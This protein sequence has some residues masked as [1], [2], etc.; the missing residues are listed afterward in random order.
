MRLDTKTDLN[1]IDEKGLAKIR[2]VAEPEYITIAKTFAALV[3]EITAVL[4]AEVTAGILTRRG[5]RLCKAVG[6]Y[7]LRWVWLITFIYI[8]ICNRT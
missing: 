7:G 3:A 2:A 6:R 8:Y 5:S 4:I 1:C